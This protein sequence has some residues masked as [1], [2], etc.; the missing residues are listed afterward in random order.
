[1]H[2]CGT[3]DH[4]REQKRIGPP[5]FRRRWIFG[6]TV[7]QRSEGQHRGSFAASM[8]GQFVKGLNEYHHNE[9][10]SR[11]DHGG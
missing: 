7:K 3:R 9:R 10:K 8:H 4:R 11:N 1:M 5:I 2:L 6:D